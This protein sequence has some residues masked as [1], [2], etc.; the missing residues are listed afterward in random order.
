MSFLLK[1]RYEGTR[2]FSSSH[3]HRRMF[4]QLPQHALRA[5]LVCLYVTWLIQ[6]ISQLHLPSRCMPQLPL[7]RMGK[8]C[9]VFSSFST[10]NLQSA[11]LPC[12]SIHLKLLSFWRIVVVFV[13]HGTVVFSSSIPDQYH[14]TCHLWHIDLLQANTLRQPIGGE[15]HNAQTTQM[16][17]VVAVNLYRY[18]IGV[19][20]L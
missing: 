13:F 9:D 19:V 20:K 18:A 15:S 14:G 2:A 16:T 8:I 12:I 10:F 3:L 17:P 7:V 11:R 4:V 6:D 1:C 5:T